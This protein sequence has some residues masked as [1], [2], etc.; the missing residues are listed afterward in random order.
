M[1]TMNEKTSSTTKLSAR[2]LAEMAAGAKVLR[3]ARRS[4]D[5]AVLKAVGFS[6]ARDLDDEALEVN[7]N[8]VKTLALPLPNENYRCGICGNQHK[9]GDRCPNSARKHVHNWSEGI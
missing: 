4:G 6:N 2:T 8:L 1:T 3:N 9:L 5:L 7:L